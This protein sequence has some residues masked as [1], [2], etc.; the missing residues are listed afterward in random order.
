MPQA[1]ISRPPMSSSTFIN[2]GTEPQTTFLVQGHTI[3]HQWNWLSPDL[4]AFV[5]M[6]LPL[7]PCLGKRV[8]RLISAYLGSSLELAVSLF[9]FRCL[10]FPCVTGSWQCLGAGKLKPRTTPVLCF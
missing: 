7:V 1:N 5:P 10:S 4:M 8:V 2:K 9:L 6:A 3:C